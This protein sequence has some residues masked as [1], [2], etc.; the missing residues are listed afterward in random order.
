[1]R[2]KNSKGYLLVDDKGRTIKNKMK[3]TPTPK[4]VLWVNE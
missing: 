2:V 3:L 1:M 4:I